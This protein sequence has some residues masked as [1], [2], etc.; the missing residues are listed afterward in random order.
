MREPPAA[1]Q[2]RVGVVAVGAL[3]ADDVDV[4]A[5]PQLDRVQRGLAVRVDLLLDAD[6]HGAV[7]ADLPGAVG[8]GPAGAE[9]EI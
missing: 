9:G 6:G 5:A 8:A 4:V 7:R 1:V 2:E 3:R